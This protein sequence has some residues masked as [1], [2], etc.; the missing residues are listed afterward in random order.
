MTRG[1]H[2]RAWQHFY[3]IQISHTIPLPWRWRTSCV[4]WSEIDSSMWSPHMSSEWHILIPEVI[5]S[6]VAMNEFGAYP[7]PVV[8]VRSMRSS[9]SRWVCVWMWT[10]MVSFDAKTP[11]HNWSFGGR[12][13]LKV[14][15]VDAEQ[16]DLNMS[17]D[18]LDVFRCYDVLLRLVCHGISKSKMIIKYNYS[19][20]FHYEASSYW[21]IPI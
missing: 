1:N 13:A 11:R 3:S 15:L 7:E 21:V 9:P 5:R 4:T 6:P 10:L 8:P 2:G 16:K 14:C 19:K 17:L 18:S 20:I 12:L